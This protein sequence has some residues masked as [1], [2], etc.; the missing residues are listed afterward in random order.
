MSYEL[1]IDII[2]NLNRLGYSVLIN[3]YEVVLS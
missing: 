1:S 3:S 2:E